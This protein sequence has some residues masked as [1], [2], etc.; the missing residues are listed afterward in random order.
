MQDIKIP[1]PRAETVRLVRYLQEKG[2][3]ETSLLDAEVFYVARHLEQTLSKDE[4]KEAKERVGAYAER[5]EGKGGGA[6]YEEREACPFLRPDDWFCGLH[7]ARPIVCRAM[8]SG[9]LKACKTAYDNRDSTVPAPS[10]AMFFKNTTAYYSAYSSALEPLGIKCYPVDL[11]KALGVVWREKNAMKRWLG[12][13][14]L[15]QEAWI[16]RAGGFM[17][18]ED[19]QP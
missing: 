7:T 14:D 16:K 8:H 15:F 11:A 3:N 19:E 2:V 9:S 10:M 5:N 13:E 17:E 12:G 1:E 18:S 4:L 6:R